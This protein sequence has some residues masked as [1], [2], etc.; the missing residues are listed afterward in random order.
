MKSI[1]YLHVL[2]PNCVITSFWNFS[3]NRLMG[4]ELSPDDSSLFT[5]FWV[6]V[7]EPPG[8]MTLAA[9]LRMPAT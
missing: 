1:I 5:W 4:D 2:C 6:P 3:K 9:R 8:G 7:E